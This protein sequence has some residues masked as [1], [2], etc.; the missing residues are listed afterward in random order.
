MS[1]AE[2]WIWFCAVIVAIFLAVTAV[3]GGW[4]WK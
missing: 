1:P 4:P 3:V 2:F